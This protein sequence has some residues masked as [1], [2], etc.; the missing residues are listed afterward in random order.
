ML[1]VLEMSIHSDYVALGVVRQ[2][3]MVR[4]G[5]KVCPGEGRGARGSVTKYSIYFVLMILLL[6]DTL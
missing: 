2:R 5:E 4:L 6:Y 3:I 1:T